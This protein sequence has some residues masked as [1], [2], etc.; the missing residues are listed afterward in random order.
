MEIRINNAILHILDATSALPVYSRETLHLDDERIHDFIGKHIE[1][2]FEDQSVKLGKFMGSSQIERFIENIREDFVDT[3]ISIAEI[4]YEL[5]QKYTEI[6][7]GDLLISLVNSDNKNYLAIL[8]FNYKEGYTHYVDY[9]DSGTLNKIVINKVMFPSETQ[10]NI[11]AALIDLED[12]SI[13]VFE[14]EYDIEGGKIE[15]FSKLFLE[16]TTNLS[17]KESI[18]VIRDVAKDITKRYYDDDFDKVSAIKEAIYENL[19][20]GTIEVENVA[21][22]IFKNSPDIKNEYIERVESAGV[23][24]IVDLDGKKP[25]KKLTVHKIKMDNGIQ[26]D[27]PVDIY[28]NKNIIEFVNNSDGTI[29]IIIKNINKIKQGN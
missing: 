1:R 29:S 24:R 25:E 15:Y 21:N 23:D 3:S 7:C 19:D 10:R 18:K 9:G 20:S 8:K 17:I 27:I 28:R 12:L 14:R 26:L 4:L 5:M 11:E 2:L 22:A 16:C 13:K 6:P